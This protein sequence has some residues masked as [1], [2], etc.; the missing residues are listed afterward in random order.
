MRYLLCIVMLIMYTGL[1]GQEIELLGKYHYAS[2]GAET[3][4]FR[5][6]D[7]FY[8]NSFWC[9]SGR[10]GKGTC[11]IHNNCLYLYFEK[12]A[13]VNKSNKF[14]INSKPSETA[15]SIRFT[16]IDED[17]I[18]LVATMIRIKKS[19]GTEILNYTDNQGQLTVKLQQRDFPV[20]VTISSIG[21]GEQQIKLD[22]A[23]DY[24]VQAL[25]ESYVIEQLV[26][27]EVYVYEM[28]DVSEDVI[29]LRPQGAK[30][31]FWKYARLLKATK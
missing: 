31:K 20:V 14:A 12:K 13:P 25:L 15:A 28:G 3:I 24:T 2:L 11:A 9:T 17:S 4:E 8:L 7:S 30:G 1:Y 29:E 21:Y 18:Q 22:S 10:E 6:M 16:V 27:G 19:S 5:G 23:A 26:N